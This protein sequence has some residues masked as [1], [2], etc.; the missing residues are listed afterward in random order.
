MGACAHVSW[1]LRQPNRGSSQA[2]SVNPAKH[3]DTDR[4]TCDCQAR[5]PRIDTE[6]AQPREPN[7]PTQHIT[8]CN[9]S[10][11]IFTI[12]ANSHY[13]QYSTIR[14]GNKQQSKTKQNKTGVPKHTA[15][16]NSTAQH[17][18]ATGLGANRHTWCRPIHRCRFH[19]IRIARQ[20]RRVSV[21]TT[22]CRLLLPALVFSPSFSVFVLFFFNLQRQLVEELC[23]F[24]IASMWLLICRCHTV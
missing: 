13:H 10:A 3:A 9:L 11:E 5:K 20:G 16:Q 22:P 23:N 17:S 6:F 12:Q 15:A 21:E 7:E 1:Q 18:T 24:I 14:I 8:F 2:S 4:Y 19:S